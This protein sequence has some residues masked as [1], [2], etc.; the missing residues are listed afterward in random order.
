MTSPARHPQPLYLVT[1]DAG[2]HPE[3][4]ARPGWGGPPPVA[5]PGDRCEPWPLDDR[6]AAPL[7]R[8]AA[9]LG[10]AFELA[11][12]VT[13]ERSLL[14]E[15]LET[16]GLSDATATLD[17]A[18]RAATVTGELSEPATAYLLAL[19]RSMS[20]RPRPR[21]ILVLPMRLTERVGLVAP[22]SRL[23]AALLPS[24]IAWE[25]AAVVAGRTMTEWA[26]LLL[27]A[28]RAP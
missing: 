3:P 16:V 17:V 13:V 27:L 24:A 22:E 26:A 18:A 2:S 9:D 28:G 25:R 1:G 8:T 15:D 5:R 23:D 12:V 19:D 7:A 21:N 10:V 4:T 11:A 14:A 20:A 6:A